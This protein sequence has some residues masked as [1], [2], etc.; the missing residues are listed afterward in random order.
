VSTELQLLHWRNGQTQSERLAAHLLALEGFTQIQPQAPLGGPDGRKDIIC[1]RAG[2]TYVAASYFPPTNKEFVDV[3][4]KFES[5]AEGVAMNGAKGFAFVTNQRL[6][7]GERKELVGLLSV[8]V[9]LLDL[10]RLVHLLDSPAGL[11]LRAAFLGIAMSAE[12]SATFAM[13]LAAV[14]E[15]TTESLK[16]AF[17][18]LSSRSVTE[19]PQPP[20]TAKRLGSDSVL[21]RWL[22]SLHRALVN[23]APNPEAVGVLR[24]VDVWV[25]S[26]ESTEATAAMV[27]IPPSEVPERIEELLADWETQ[28]ENVRGASRTERLNAI[29][30]FHHEFLVVHPFLDGNGT[31]ARYLLKLQ[32]AEF[33]GLDFD[34]SRLDIVGYVVAL[35]IA[36]HTRELTSLIHN[37][38]IGCS[39]AGF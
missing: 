3:R 18:D 14:H 27:P 7:I 1:V 21:V 19:R 6:T 8:P 31:I 37:I 22:L 30:K 39:G 11:G 24:G 13:H 16:Q 4:K 28:R 12:D 26:P 35:Q 5:D 15:R 33:C 2:V 25:G 23:D 10:E 17:L 9:D 29:A 34:A 20:V 36:D 32:L 38:E